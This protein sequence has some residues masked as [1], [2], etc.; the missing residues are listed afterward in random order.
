MSAGFARGS[1][2]GLALTA[3]TI[4]MIIEGAIS[5]LV[6]IAAYFSLPNWANNTPWMSAEETEMA[7]YRIVLSAG[8]NDENDQETSL[9][10]GTKLAL[11]D[12][13]T[14]L[15]M[16]MH[17]WLVA[18]QSFKDFLPSIVSWTRVKLTIVANDEH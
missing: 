7:Q 13:F 2:V 16:G 3:L 17:M 4:V 8:G 11:K 5:I 6:A 10:Q 1:G 15:F 18:A 12:T 9:W 14:W